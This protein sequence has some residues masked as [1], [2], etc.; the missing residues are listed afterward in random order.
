MESNRKVWEQAEEEKAKT[1]QLSA[2]K[3][4]KAA[5]DARTPVSA[6]SCCKSLQQSGCFLTTVCMLQ[7]KAA[8]VDLTDECEGGPGDE[9][10]EEVEEEEEEAPKD[11]NS[12]VS[13]CLAL[14][15][16]CSNLVVF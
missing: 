1:S 15:S 4:A 5:K 6:R 10:E 11:A 7:A 14:R 12:P 9:E 8:P 3:D 2:A 16:C 13:G